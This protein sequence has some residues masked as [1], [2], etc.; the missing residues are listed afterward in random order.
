MSVAGMLAIVAVTAVV[1]LTPLVSLEAVEYG[2]P[3]V[4]VEVRVWQGVGDELDIRV[5]A[6][7]ADGSWRRLGTI[8]LALDDGFSSSG[9]YR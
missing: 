2:A 4:R 6:R 7:P 9:Q 5:S 1:T 3:S 8:P